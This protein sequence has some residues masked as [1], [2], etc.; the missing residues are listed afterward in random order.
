MESVSE[1]VRSVVQSADSLV[2]SGY[3]DASGTRVPA[4]ALERSLVALEE[5]AKTRERTLAQAHDKLSQFYQLLD[6]TTN[7]IDNVKYI[8][9]NNYYSLL[10]IFCLFLNSL[11]DKVNK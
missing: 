8:I 1:G 2:D 9:Y 7:N 3:C 6:N 11:I 5:R 4:A 10:F